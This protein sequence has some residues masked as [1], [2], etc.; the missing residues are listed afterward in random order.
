V[1]GLPAG[2]DDPI[3]SYTPALDDRIQC[4][5]TSDV[6]CPVNNPAFSPVVALEVYAKPFVSLNMCVLQTSRD[7][8]PFLLKGGLPLGGTYSGTAVTNGYFSPFQ[9]PANQNSAAIRY[10][11]TTSHGCTDTAGGII[12]VAPMQAFTCGNRV[13]DIRDNS[14]Y[15]T[16]Q[17]GMQCWF[18]DNLNYGLYITSHTLQ[19]DNCIPEKYCYGD[20][21]D[22]CT[23]G[24][25]LYTWNEM[26]QYSESAAD[27]GLCPPGWHVP[28]ENDWD[29]LFSFYNGKSRAAE[30]LKATGDGFFNAGTAGALFLGRS[31]NFSQF[32][33]FF[34]SSTTPDV[35]SGFA[36]G[37]NIRDNSV[38]DYRAS[39]MDSFSVRCIKN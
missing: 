8:L 37:I 22:Y 21:M 7:A 14:S 12:S 15:A 39:R 29:L 9:L 18:R 25:G 27:Q 33:G 1:N 28:D 24:G 4:S 23:T 38:S 17:L 20:V 36:H 3:F 11:M 10:S 26:M 31:W 19:F 32:A 30:F 2:N 6:S 13:T 16:V 35:S 5:L 34:W